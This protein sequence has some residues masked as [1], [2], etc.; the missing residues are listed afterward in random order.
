MGFQKRRILSLE[1][2]GSQQ[3][4][5]KESHGGQVYPCAIRFDQTR[6]IPPPSDPCDGLLKASRKRAGFVRSASVTPP[7]SSDLENGL[8]SGQG[9]VD[10]KFRTQMTS[11]RS[12]DKKECRARFVS[13]GEPSHQQKD[14][15]KSPTTGSARITLRSFY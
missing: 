7:E 12:D 10:D 4:P 5:G 13:P 9:G 14:A 11:R 8:S 6:E 3:A 1:M 15:C 2:G